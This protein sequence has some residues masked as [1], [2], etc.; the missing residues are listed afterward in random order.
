MRSQA[1]KQALR[2]KLRRVGG[3]SESPASA[4]AAGAA[5][6]DREQHE[7]AR[8][9]LATAEAALQ[10]LTRFLSRELLSRELRA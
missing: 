8:R 4:A 9:Q 7:A 2:I 3:E 1:E 5:R 10:V 6:D